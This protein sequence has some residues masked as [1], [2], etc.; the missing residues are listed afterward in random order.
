MENKFDQLSQE[1]ATFLNRYARFAK[2]YGLNLNELR[3]LYYLAQHGQV[4]PGEIGNHWS[5]AKQTVTSLFNKFRRQGLVEATIDPH[6]A[7]RRL[8]TLTAA[9]QDFLKPLLADLAAA[10]TAASQT[11]G[12]ANFDQVLTGLAALS[13][14]LGDNLA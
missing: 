9:G 4:A 13:A 2:R 12:D 3:F 5:L 8:L 11:V 7:R 14:A 1:I 6:D 10:E